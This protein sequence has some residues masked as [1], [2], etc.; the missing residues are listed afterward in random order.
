[1]EL[2]ALLSA[3]AGLGHAHASMWRYSGPYVYIEAYE[4]TAMGGGTQ[5]RLHTAQTNLEPQ[6][7]WRELQRRFV[8]QQRVPSVSDCL[9]VY[10]P[11]VFIHQAQRAASAL[12]ASAEGK[13]I[14]ISKR[15]LLKFCFQW[16]TPKG[17]D[18]P[19]TMQ[20]FFTLPV[21]LLEGSSNRN[22]GFKSFKTNKRNVDL[23]FSA[24]FNHLKASFIVIDYNETNLANS[25]TINLI[26][27]FFSWTEINKMCFLLICPSWL[28]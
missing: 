23:L 8:L 21:R 17:S 2:I 26:T 20:G 24:A 1:M 19:S 18:A 4:R 22:T 15:V 6:Q 9:S 11:S 3:E 27:L 28:L 5:R 16:I 25:K 13:H 7:R 12:F 14:Q 10:C